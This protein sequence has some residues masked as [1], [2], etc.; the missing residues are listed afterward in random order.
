[1]QIKL[2]LPM[3]VALFF[4]GSAN[5]QDFGTGNFFYQQCKTPT[6]FCLGYFVGFADANAAN[7]GARQKSHYCAPGGVTMQQLIAV[8]IKYLDDNPGE[9]HK[10]FLDLVPKALGAAFPCK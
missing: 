8:T 9:R 1:M 10:M 2:A 6:E 7:V 5:A 4:H 3:A